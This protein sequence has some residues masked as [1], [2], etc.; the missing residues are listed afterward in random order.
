MRR[1]TIE[2]V[3]R[4][5][6]RV[7]LRCLSET[8][9]KNSAPLTFVCS[10]AH[11]AWNMTFAELRQGRS[12]ATC[13]GSA[14]VAERVCRAFFVGWFGVSFPRSNPQWLRYPASGRLLQLDGYNIELRLA[15]EHQGAQHYRPRRDWGK[16]ERDVVEQQARDAWKSEACARQG[17]RL[18]VLREV[19]R[20][21]PVAHLP[22]AMAEQCAALGI[23]IPD[24]WRTRA[25]DRELLHTPTAEL[26]LREFREIATERGWELLS[27]VYIPSDRLAFR[28]GACASEWAATPVDVRQG[29]SC[30]VCAKRVPLGLDACRALAANRGGACLATRYTNNKTLLSWRCREPEH[31]PFDMRAAKVRDG[32]WCPR[33]GR[34]RTAAARRGSIERMR[35][36]AADRNGTCVSDRYEGSHAVLRWQCG[37][38]HP[39]FKMTPNNV[40]A[41]QWCPICG[42]ARSAAARRTSIETL[43][44]FAAARGWQL[45]SRQYG[46]KSERLLWRCA[47]GHEWC[48]SWGNVLGRGSGCPHCTRPRGVGPVRPA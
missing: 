8:Y 38:G 10:E 29:S 7:G 33:C 28:C 25:P 6:E 15:F 18:V 31:P 14:P 48:A 45:L 20:H 36:W 47:V 9:E 32:Q 13:R 4:V 24:D 12:C 11:P 30:P 3:R 5:A 34:M 41:G 21:T 46:N 42:R 2:H 26:L 27:T 22:G 16:T 17:V 40:Q 23:A 43:D 19:G 1:H 44:A 37:A 39:P 35:G